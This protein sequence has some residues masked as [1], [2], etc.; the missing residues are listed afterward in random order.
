MKR[1]TYR[2]A[3]SLLLAGQIACTSIANVAGSALA[4]S[5]GVISSGFESF[6]LSYG[7]LDHRAGLAPSDGAVKALPYEIAVEKDRT[8]DS[9]SSINDKIVKWSSD[10]DGAFRMDTISVK[11][12]GSVYRTLGELEEKLGRLPDYQFDA[13]HVYGGT[14][15]TNPALDL[16]AKDP[17]KYTATDADF[18]LVPDMPL[19]MGALRATIVQNEDAMQNGA[20]GF[21]SKDLPVIAHW[22]LSNNATLVDKAKVNAKLAEDRTEEETAIYAVTNK[23]EKLE[24]NLLSQLYDRDLNEVGALETNFDPGA[25]NTV[26]YLRVPANVEKLD[27]AV[28]AAE[29]FR[30]LEIGDKAGVVI[31]VTPAGKA[32]QETYQLS[33]SIL[34]DSKDAGAGN[35]DIYNNLEYPMRSKWETDGAVYPYIPLAQST[36]GSYYNEVMVVVTAPDGVTEN[37][38]TFYIQ[39]LNDPVILQNPGNTPLGMI[40]RDTGPVWEAASKETGKSIEELK[41]DAKEG[42][43]VLNGNKKAYAFDSIFRPGGEENNYGVI[44]QSVYHE[45]AWNRYGVNYDLDETA[46]VVYQDSSFVDPGFNV[47]DSQGN[48]VAFGNG[49]DNLKRSVCLRL[50]TGEAGLTV[51]EVKDH[52]GEPYYYS[53]DQGNLTEVTPDVDTFQIVN[54]AE[55]R[56]IIDLRGANVVPGVYH[57]EYSY[58]DPLSDQTYT[59][60]PDTFQ[61]ANIESAETFRRTLIVL[62]VPGDV[63]MDGAVTAADAELLRRALKPST[64]PDSHD[65]AFLDWEDNV[66]A[67]F[68]ARV[69]DVNGD[70]K[71]D[72]TDVEAIQRGFTPTLTAPDGSDYF[73]VP[74]PSGL[75]MEEEQTWRAR[76]AL[77]TEADESKATLAFAFL[78]VNN[79]AV[80]LDPNQL[81][82]LS[83]VGAA[84]Q[85]DDVFWVGIKVSDL[86]RLVNTEEKRWAIRGGIASIHMTI[87]YDAAYVEPALLPDPSSVDTEDEQWLSTLERYNIGTTDVPTK[88]FWGGHY[89]IAEGTEG[90]VG[91]T[92][93]YS[94]AILPLEGAVENQN[95]LRQLTVSIR[96]KQNDSNYRTLAE[97]GDSYLL[98]IPFRLHTFP[99]GQTSA[100]IMDLGLG[101]QEL[102][103]FSQ[104]VPQNFSIPQVAA[105][106]STQNHIFGDATWNLRD[107]LAYIGGSARKIP[108][109]E[110]KTERIFLENGRGGTVYGEP[111]ENKSLQAGLPGAEEINSRLPEGLTYHSDTGVIDGTPEEVGSFEFR[112]VSGN[113]TQRIYSIR[114]ERA[115][116]TLTAVPQERYYGEDNA[117]LD[118]SYRPEDIKALDLEHGANY[119]SGFRND[120][121]SG[122]LKKLAGYAAPLLTTNATMRSG[123]GEYEIVITDRPDVGSGLENYRFVYGDTSGATASSLLKV[124]PRPIVI[125]RVEDDMDSPHN[126]MAGVSVRASDPRTVFEVT[127]K[128]GGGAA[129]FQAV[130]PGADYEGMAL[131]APAICD[132]D[133]LTI[134]FTA[135]LSHENNT[136]PYYNF[137]PG[138]TLKQVDAALSGI[139]LTDGE[140]NGNYVLVKPYL[141]VTTAK[142][143]VLNNPVVEISVENLPK[144]TG[145]V[146]GEA[147]MYSGMKVTLRYEN[148]ET[149]D[150]TYSGDESFQ[151]AGIVVTWEE[152][153]DG[154]PHRDDADRRLRNGQLLNA[155]V[156]SGKYLCVSVVGYREGAEGP[157][158]AYAETP[159]SISKKQLALGVVEQR[160]YY[161]EFH[162][163]TTPLT[164]TY[165]PMELSS[166]DQA[167]LKA[168]TGKAVLDGTEEELRHLP[169]Y[170]AP[171]LEARA[172][173][174]GDLV[175]ADTE[176]GTRIIYIDYERD[177]KGNILTGADDYDFVFRIGAGAAGTWGEPGYNN[178]YILPR[179]IVVRELSM[180]VDGEES[181]AF[182]YDDTTNYVLSQMYDEDGTTHAVA[183]VGQNGDQGITADGFVAALPGNEYYYQGEGGSQIALRAPLDKSGGAIHRKADGTLDRVVVSYTATYTPDNPAGDPLHGTPYFQLEDGETEKLVTAKIRSLKL[184]SDAGSANRN[185]ILVY[186]TLSTANTCKPKT[187]TAQ[188]R[189]QMRALEQVEVLQAPS[190][191]TD[192][193]YGDELTLQ[194][195]RLQLRYVSQGDNDPA[196][197]AGIIDRTLDYELRYLNGVRTNSLA[198]QG[199]KV[200]WM[201]PAQTLP[202]DLN[203]LSGEQLA[204]LLG[205]DTDT[206]DYP[207][208]SENGKK[209]LVCGRRAERHALVWAETADEAAFAI[210]QK[211]IP[212]TVEA[213]NRYYGEAN[214]TYRAYYLFGALARPDQERLRE[215]FTGVDFQ[216]TTKLYIT[217]DGVAGVTQEGGKDRSAPAD[218]PELSFLDPG[219][220]GVI[221]TTAGTRKAGAGQYSIDLDDSRSGMANYCFNRNTSAKLT[222]FRRPVVVDKICETPISTIYWNTPEMEFASY[223]EQA[224]QGAGA[225][226]AAGIYTV[227]PP[228]EQGGVYHSVTDPVFVEAVN[229]GMD[230]NLTLSGDAIYGGDTIGIGMTVVFP[231]VSKR[232]NIPQE[233]YLADQPVTIRDM[234]LTAGVENYI[235]VYNDST[236]QVER[237]PADRSAVGQLDRRTI[238]KIEIVQN[239]KMDYV[240]GEGLDLSRLKVGITFDE[241]PNESYDTYEEVYYHQYGG[242]YINY[243][244]SPQLPAEHGA[245][246]LARAAAQGDHL[247]IAPDHSEEHFVY[248][249]KYIIITARAHET[250]NFAAPVLVSD[251]AG[252]PVPLAVAPLDLNYTLSAE[253]KVYDGTSR[254]SGAITLTNPY[255]N[256]AG[257]KDGIFVVTGADYEKPGAGQPYYS[258]YSALLAY[259]EEHGYTF[260]SGLTGLRFQFFD[261]NVTY[262]DERHSSDHPV[263]VQD[264]QGYWDSLDHSPKTPQG[265]GWDTYGEVAPQPVLVGGIVLA[266]PDAANY[267]LDGAVG[268]TDNVDSESKSTAPYAAIEKAERPL[269]ADIRPQLS[270]DVHTNAVKLTYTKEIS[271]VRDTADA[272]DGEIHYEYGLEYLAVPPEGGAEAVTR[273]GGEDAW[274]DGY[275]FGGEQITCP[276]P[277]GYEPSREP[278]PPKETD[279]VKG[280]IYRWAED[281]AH[282]YDAADTGLGT[283]R[284]LPGGTVFWGVARIAETHNYKASELVSSAAD[285]EAALE[286]AEREARER[287]Q[288]LLAQAEKHDKEFVQD[289]EPVPAAAVKTYPQRFALISTAQERGVDGESYT[290]P[291]LEAVWFTDLLLYEKKEVL[292]AAVRNAEPTRYYGYYWDIDQSAPLKFD[293]PGLDLSGPLTVEVNEK[294]PAGGS[295]KKDIVVNQGGKADV[296]V[297]ITSGGGDVYAKS[298]SVEPQRVEAELGRAPLQMKVEY[299]PRYTTAKR[300]AWASS[301]EQVVQ[302]TEEGLLL[303]VGVGSATITVTTTSNGM[304]TTVPVTVGDPAGRSQG[305]GVGALA[306]DHKNARFDFYHRDAFLALDGDGYF[307]PDRLMDRAELV[308]TLARFYE[309]PAHWKWSGRADFPDLTGREYYAAAAE[310]LLEEGVLTGLPDGT[311]GG[312]QVATRA[313]MAV[314]L[315]RMMGLVPADTRGQRH[316]FLDAGEEDTW[317]YAYIDALAKAGVLNGTGDGYFSPNRRIT[318][319]EVAAM[320][321][322]ILRSGAYYGQDGNLNIPVDVPEGHWG[323]GPILRAVNDLAWPGAY[324]KLLGSS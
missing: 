266:G 102:A 261:A 2:K 219:Y 197:N 75:S 161:G 95:T 147:L 49:A 195:L 250:T 106:W 236:A 319:A 70:G 165:D 145:Y 9:S 72:S 16:K 234:T 190:R 172:S 93:H 54:D 73:Y 80:T 150:Y 76:K 218:S 91:Y 17:E 67:L 276:W 267:T 252:A 260:G 173:V 141:N 242:L 61:P 301:D 203:Q 238:N 271:Q 65:V 122:E 324:E 227:L 208:L 254:A 291:T 214:G 8:V 169:G 100:E 125:D 60:D 38:Y 130:L 320:L 187:D 126:A 15:Q 18:R 109:G 142:A 21:G 294:Q 321:G 23:G 79:D 118:Y 278:V 314:I 304:S 66:T 207:S 196:A 74:L 178:L 243:W 133:E 308:Y 200:Y 297:S 168:A 19:D 317:A 155:G 138:Q 143:T 279:V 318:R 245:G 144:L 101:M 322:R 64:A 180:A 41:E 205:P 114:V 163:D 4:A 3:V 176:V 225:G 33:Q 175:T 167:V 55:G 170:R 292:D 285:R 202:E 286:Q 259:L 153:K 226:A 156:H 92:T 277:D 288:A 174:T 157:V 191:R 131:T 103:L 303:F 290:V 52:A 265:E 115:P 164:F 152:E 111:Y 189:V 300:V 231:E 181:Q 268:L 262:G 222:V 199:L 36:A 154:A 233:T 137:N 270:L 298:I 113:G 257:E 25:Q 136:D 127:A 107:E 40:A 58:Y 12:K 201:D 179:P 48:L 209:L 246:V 37:T 186:D 256:E 229:G 53:E 249:G 44:Y 166:Q 237:A 311:F 59:S 232:V 310:L 116:L 69:C 24:G 287:A 128:S 32:E 22:E 97:A 78:G 183:A 313:E 273:W 82:K 132:W 35:Y 177:G 258:D 193:I 239:P 7:Y 99:F 98:R 34:N 5:D 280:Q 1:N 188:G 129:G 171:I 86:A 134:A 185:Y 212:L 217:A 96:I 240:Y 77:T 299:T 283:R 264:W 255:V 206:G 247:T 110:D 30:S 216:N 81:E 151:E 211:P 306:L 105:V 316:A 244:D 253:D 139:R 215:Q 85:K 31:Q 10:A 182:L 84:V 281:G 220:A 275:Y 302:V 123:T 235:L 162:K 241:I 27:V 121:S 323:Y 160:I 213:Q 194:G 224:G 289:P 104:I 272:Y 192:Y 83:P 39:R 296:Y 149:K 305:I 148:G 263:A 68:K 120:G 228:L 20:Y 146:Y 269:S 88:E 71:V 251:G 230:W 94:K 56:D 6:Y 223:A 312:A 295:V 62:P 124:E 293:K 45:N 42:F 50:A 119:V 63:D 117:P 274:Q 87:A 309:A 51:K 204:A 108:L 158:C 57:M 11:E 89:T 284:E 140:A 14:I 43:A 47:V 315:C 307:Y 184:T 135:T 28:L 90:D 13:W 248:N 159:F 46:I 112:V 282:W 26:Y 198:L 221:F 210:R 29:P